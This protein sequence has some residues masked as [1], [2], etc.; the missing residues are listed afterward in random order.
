MAFDYPCSPIR[1]EPLHTRKPLTR[2]SLRCLPACQRQVTRHRRH[3][4][5]RRSAGSAH[6]ETPCRDYA[7]DADR[8][9]I[10][11]Q[12]CGTLSLI[13]S[14]SAFTGDPPGL[15]TIQRGPLMLVYLTDVRGERVV[16]MQVN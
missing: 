15:R 14:W 13:D 7:F 12:P 16:I 4:A 5:R 10:C 6:Q 3:V 8:G 11:R 2:H 9:G 1:S